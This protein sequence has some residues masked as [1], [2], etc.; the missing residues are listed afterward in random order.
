M[1]IELPPVNSAWSVREPWTVETFF[2]CAEKKVMYHKSSKYKPEEDNVD[3]C[4]G[5]K[6]INDKNV[7]EKS[8]KSMAGRVLLEVLF[9]WSCSSRACTFAYVHA[10]YDRADT[11]AVS[12]Q[13]AKFLT[14]PLPFLFFLYSSISPSL[15]WKDYIVQLVWRY[16]RLEFL[17]L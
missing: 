4:H 6:N 14:V 11:A 8:K 7:K 15:S 5:K 3:I 10:C 2:T 12:V 9:F 1:F 13:F 17:N 16:L